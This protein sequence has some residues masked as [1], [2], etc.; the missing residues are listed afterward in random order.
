MMCEKYNYQSHTPQNLSYI[1]KKIPRGYSLEGLTSER[2]VGIANYIIE[3]NAAVRQTAK[4]YGVSK[5][6]VHMLLHNRT[7]CGE[8]DLG[9]RI[10]FLANHTQ[11]SLIGIWFFYAMEQGQTSEIDRCHST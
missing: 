2:A 8:S 6:T 3:R 1:V 5:S 4:A 10:G 9:N 7:V 11:K